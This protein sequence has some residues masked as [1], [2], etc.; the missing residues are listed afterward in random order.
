MKF[1]TAILFILSSVAKTTKAQNGF[2]EGMG[3]PDGF[4]PGVNGL[5]SICENYKMRARVLCN[6]YCQAQDCYLDEGGNTPPEVCDNVYDN[7]VE[8]TNEEPPCEKFC[9][10]FSN[11]DLASE[12]TC[13][14]IRNPVTGEI[15]SYALFDTEE[16]D[17]LST[18]KLVVATLGDFPSC[19]IG[20]PSKDSPLIGGF[21]TAEKGQNC[22]DLI[23]GAFSGEGECTEFVFPGP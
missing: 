19:A 15:V 8:A 23:A 14:F 21:L 5:L 13:E 1:I 3:T 18:T 7:F 11:I 2:F 10:C 22:F 9:P 12:L 17:P 16:F 6:V 4:T 20:D